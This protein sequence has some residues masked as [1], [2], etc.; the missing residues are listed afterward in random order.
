MTI[1]LAL[2]PDGRWDFDTE[3]VAAASAAAGFTAIS[4]PVAHA[5]ATALSALKSNGVRGHDVLA[6]MISRN[7]AKSEESAHRA[8]AAAAAIEAG[9]ALTVFGVRPGPE[10]SAIIRRCAD[11]LAEAG[12]RMAVE[13]SPLG[14]LSS[15]AAGIEVVDLVGVD[16][17]GVMIDTWH[18][19][20]GDS[21]W[22]QLAQIPF[23][24]IAYVQFDDALAAE[25]DDGF[26]ET[27]NR[28][29]FPGD[30]MFDLERFAATLIDRGW[31]GTV[32]VEVLSSELATLPVPEFARRAFDTTAPY[33]L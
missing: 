1:E 3:A 20:R 13:F 9:W 23:E 19:F 25:S 2:T 5:D 15:I 30:G 12:V 8:A 33:W 11:I 28:R 27:M 26:S 31:S 7:E 14:A 24:K 16:R 10:S 17:A 32:S 29:A 6:V 18:F 22:A 4:V 21:T